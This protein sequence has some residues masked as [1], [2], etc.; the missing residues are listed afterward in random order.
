M[1]KYQTRAFQ[2]GEYYLGRRGASPAFYR[3]RYDEASRTTIRHS[4]GTTDEEE[5]KAKLLDWYVKNERDKVESATATLGEIFTSYE[6]NHAPAL[7]SYKTVTILLRHWL[8]Y[9]GKDTDVRDIKPVVKQ[10]AFQAHLASKGLAPNSVNRVLEIGRAAINRAYKRGMIDAA[11][12]IHTLEPQL[13]NPK[14][15]PLAPEEIKALYLASADHIRLFIILMLGT[16]A[17]NE[18]VTSLTWPQIEFEGGLVYLN[19]EGRKQTSKRRPTVRLIPTVRK[20]LEP[21]PKD[22][23]AVLM[24]RGE[25]V[26][27]I[28]TG[29]DKAVARAELKGNVVP[30]SLRHSA[31]RWMRKEGV[32]PWETAMQLGHKMPQFS[33][34]ERYAAWSPDYLDQAAAALEKLLCLS[35]PPDAPKIPSAR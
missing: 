7:R 6:H 33:M 15:R 28:R 10:E 4:L 1:S 23:P 5:A 12:F 29:W 27:K 16:A 8:D 3:C 26:G 13:D 20:A 2:V 11:P 19:P 24:F 14:G 22:T 35:V 21:L 17:R 34:T 9:W 32:P 31:S 18:A 30:Y 25:K